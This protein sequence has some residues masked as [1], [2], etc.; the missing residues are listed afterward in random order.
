ML[1]LKTLLTP[2][3]VSLALVITTPAFA[4][5]DRGHQRDGMR[6]ILS[7]LSL[8][9]A[10]KQ[11]IKEIRKQ[12]RLDKEA[13]QEGGSSFFSELQPLIQATEWDQTQ[14]EI[15]LAQHQAA[16]SEKMLHR[17]EQKNQVWNT[18]TEAQQAEFS[19]LVTE[20]QAERDAKREE[21]QDHKKGK[22]R[23]KARMFRGLDLTDTQKAD[24]K[25]VREQAKAT[26]AAL[27]D[28]LK[29]FKKSERALVNSTDFT[30]EKWQALS[31]QYQ[32]DFLALAVSKAKVNHD[33]WNLLTVEQ[34]QKMSEKIEKMKSRKHHGK[35]Q[36][37]QQTV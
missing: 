22:K 10:Q 13:Y 7:Q 27:K 34:Q 14:V 18:L 26:E 9:D 3:A 24:I 5:K 17:A 23:G 29:E 30:A 6:H 16:I 25:A 2:I 32:D 21:S 19:A 4:N 15:S 36:K 28:S 11:D 33:V 20:K 12:G 35:K 1:K 31:S 8:T 37:K